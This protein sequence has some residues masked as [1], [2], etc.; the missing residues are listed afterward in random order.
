MN[1][2]A[3]QVK[4]ITTLKPAF[5]LVSERASQNTGQA[6]SGI[7]RS[8]VGNADEAVIA[9]PGERRAL[10]LAP[11]TPRTKRRQNSFELR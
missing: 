2:E 1:F 10:S 8:K 3:K 4:D 9:K 11:V 7:L 5:A 6:K